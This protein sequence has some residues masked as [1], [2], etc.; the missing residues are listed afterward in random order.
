[1]FHKD[2]HIIKIQ[3]S[4][5]Y[6]YQD[7]PIIKVHV[8]SIYTYHQ[9][10]GIKI[11]VSSTLTCHQLFM[12]INYYYLIWQNSNPSVLKS[13]FQG[14]IDPQIKNYFYLQKLTHTVYKI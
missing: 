12:I 13:D 1:M 4:S 9:D 6:R 7:I 14:V 8:S 11:H 2:S 3:I 5:R 10:S